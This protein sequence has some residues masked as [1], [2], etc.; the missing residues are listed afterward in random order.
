MSVP[1]LTEVRIVVADL[2][3]ALDAWQSVVGLA[4]ATEVL[5]EE[6][7]IE[8]AGC[9][10]RLCVVQ[11]DDTPGLA[12]LQLSVPDLDRTIE[13]LGESIEAGSR[14]VDPRFSHGVRIELVDEEPA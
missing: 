2:G 7:G 3:A 8:V 6:A 1:R 13:A 14:Q 10:L 9:R 4:E 11:S 12:A 5:D